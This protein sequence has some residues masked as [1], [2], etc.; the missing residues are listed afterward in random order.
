M[1]IENSAL[2]IALL[3]EEYLES[4]NC[5]DEL[6]YAREEVAERLL[7]YLT[8]VELP[9]G[10]K[11]RTGRLQ[12]IHRYKYKRDEEFYEKLFSASGIAVCRD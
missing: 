5:K 4:Q 3:S 9:G 11:M 2:F 1:H 12:A 7:V 8:P 6:Y 10:L